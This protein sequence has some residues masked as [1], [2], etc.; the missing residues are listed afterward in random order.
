[1]DPCGRQSACGKVDGAIDHVGG[2]DV[3]AVRIWVAEKVGESNGW[4]GIVVGIIQFEEFHHCGKCED[5]RDIIDR[6]SQV[7]IVGGGDGG[8]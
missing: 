4:E 6:D 2:D 7:R 1:M 3:G 8:G 5:I